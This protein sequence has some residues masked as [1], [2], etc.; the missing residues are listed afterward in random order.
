MCNFDTV[1]FDLDGT[2]LN[3]LDDLTNSVNY[4]LEK[5]GLPKRT[6]EEIRSFVGNGIQ[7]LIKRATGKDCKQELR[8]QVFQDFKTHYGNHCNDK[9][10]LYDGIKELIQ[11][12]K[13]NGFKMAIVSNKAD[14]AVKEL[15][16]IYFQGNILVAIGEQEDKGIGKKPVPDM[17]FEAMR[18]LECEK[19]K[20]VYVGDSEVDLQ[21]AKNAG[22]PCISALW[23]FRDKEF[24]QS[25]GAL[26][27]AKEPKDVFTIL[28]NGEV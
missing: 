17:V 18:Q 9:T 14:F 8:S 28:Q 11:K 4:A 10:C 2:L 15:Q 22:L 12:L 25:Q 16:S 24:L 20:T 27:L 21:T 7:M 1:I 6:I 23:G 3:T 5:N 26:H 13:D 19:E